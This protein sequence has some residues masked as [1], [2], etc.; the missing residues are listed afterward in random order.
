MPNSL[1]LADGS[2]LHGRFINR[3]D[4]TTLLLNKKG[5]YGVSLK[6][7]PAV[8]EIVLLPDVSIKRNPVYTKIRTRPICGAECRE[9]GSEYR[10]ARK[11]LSRVIHNRSQTAISE[12]H[13]ALSNLAPLATF[14]FSKTAIAR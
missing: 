8:I 1:L 11:A 9:S 12:P 4:N 14:A 2:V 6:N 5:L 10:I 13:L 3:S 7:A